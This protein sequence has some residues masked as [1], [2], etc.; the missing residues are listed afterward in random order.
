MSLLMPTLEEVYDQLYS[1]SRWSSS[2]ITF[3]FPR[4]ARG[5][6]SNQGESVGFSAILTIGQQAARLAIALWDDLIIS[7]FQE[8]PPGLSSVVSQIE[9]GMTTTGINFAHAYFPNA[10]SIWLNSNFGTS[11]GDNNISSPEIGRHGFITYIHE[12]GHALGLDHSGDY[13]EE[14]SWVPKN[15]RDSTLFTIM[16]YFGPDRENFQG[17][18][19]A[20]WVGTDGRRYSPQTPMLDDIYVIQRIYGASTT[21]RTQDTTYGFNSNITK[22]WCLW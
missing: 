6:Y 13:N 14:G 20:D 7:N 2:I 4:D 11:S 1:R 21:T 12:I 9:F 18:L 8:I 22:H 19:Q 5:L 16:S 17:S 10:G 15:Q 3:S